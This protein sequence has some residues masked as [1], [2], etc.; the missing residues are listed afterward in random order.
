M[1]HAASGKGA[2]QSRL[3]P[4]CSSMI[5]VNDI[6]AGFAKASTACN[7]HVE[8]RLHFCAASATPGASG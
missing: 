7:N 8:M 6:S 1:L 2:K 3:H 5:A 4:A